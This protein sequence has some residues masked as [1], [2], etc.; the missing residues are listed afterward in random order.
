MVFGSAGLRDVAKRSW[1]GSISAELADFTVITA[2]DPRTESLSDIMTEI[3]SGCE[4][5][6]GIEGKTFCKISDRADAI[7]FA[8]GM[9]VSGDRFW[10]V[11]RHMNNPCVLALLNIHGMI[12]W[13]CIQ[14]LQRGWE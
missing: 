13:Q 8:V 3:A 14:L 5:I 12:E 11:V 1:M 9:A 2:E 6:G 10:L 7:R 4:K